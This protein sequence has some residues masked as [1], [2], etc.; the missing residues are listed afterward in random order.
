MARWKAGLPLELKTERFTLRSLVRAEV[1]EQL[2]GWLND[3]ELMFYLGGAWGAKDLKALADAIERLYDNKSDFMLG[4]YHEGH[5]IG[6]YWIEASLRNRSA[7]THHVFGDKSFWGKGAPHECRSAILDFLFAVGF[8]R[9]EGRP[10]ATCIRAIKGY[11]KQGW[12]MEGIARRAS[13]DRS[14]VRHDNMLFSMLPEDWAAQ[15]EAQKAKKPAQ[16]APRR[17]AG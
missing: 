5:L 10:Y 9:I 15:R 6:C 16:A 8:E 13:R 11:L 1:T 2:R 17:D 14:G 7:C 4:V 12:R 3:P